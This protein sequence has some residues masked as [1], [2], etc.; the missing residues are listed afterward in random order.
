MPDS[1]NGVLQPLEEGTEIISLSFASFHIQ[2][3]LHGPIHRKGF[4]TG[5]PRSY[6]AADFQLCITTTH[7]GP[8]DRAKELGRHPVM[9]Q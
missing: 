7:L 5:K 1:L 9:A 3:Q 6:L 8:D 4:L 2:K